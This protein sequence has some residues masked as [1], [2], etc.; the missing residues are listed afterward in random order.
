MIWPPCLSFLQIHYDHLVLLDYLISKDTGVPF[1]HYLLRCIRLVCKL[2]S[3]FVEFSMCSTEVGQPHFKRRKLRGNGQDSTEMLGHTFS[4]TDST[5]DSRMLKTGDG[6]MN[7]LD[8]KQAS[9]AVAKNLFQDAKGCLLSLKTSVEDLHR[10]NL[11]PYRPVPLIRRYANP[12]PVC[13]LIR[14]ESLPDSRNSVKLSK[15]GL[16]VTEPLAHCDIGKPSFLDIVGCPLQERWRGIEDSL[17][18]CGQPPPNNYG[19]DAY[20]SPIL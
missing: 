10:K 18:V 16:M 9:P 4:T 6:K 7:K 12:R 2:W 13:M 5:D 8:S 17:E 19:V 14:S 11:F 20:Y 3:F 15:K 1:V